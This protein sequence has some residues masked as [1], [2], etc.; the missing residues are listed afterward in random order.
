MKTKQL[1]D[2]NQDKIDNSKKVNIFIPIR[3]RDTKRLKRCVHNIKKYNLGLIDKI[4]VVDVGSKIPIKPIKKVVVE[5]LETST[6]NKA[7]ALNK[8]ILKYPNT[9]IMTCDVDTLLFKEHFEQISKSLNN[10]TFICDTNVR[11]INPKNFRDDYFVLLRKSK[12]WRNMDTQQ[13][14]NTANGGFQIYPYNFFQQMNGIQEGLGLYHGAVDNIV[15]YRA[16]MF[17][18]NIVDI[19]YPLLHMDHKKQKEENYDKEEREIALGYRSFKVGYID[20]VIKNNIFRNPETI[21]GDTCNISLFSEYK[22]AMTNQNKLIEEAIN[23]KQDSVMIGYQNFKL[24]KAQ[25][26]ILVAVINNTG[27]VPDFFMYDLINLVDYTRKLGYTCDIQ[28]VNACDVNSLRNAAVKV[29][30]GMNSDN[31]VYDYLVQ[32]DDDHRYPPEFI[33]KFIKEMEEKKIPIMTGLTPRKTFPYQNT[34]YYKNQEE[35]MAP[36]NI[37]VCKKPTDKIVDIEISGPVGMVINTSVF[38]KIPYPW[39]VMEFSKKK[40]KTKK[41]INNNGKLEEIEIETLKDHQTGGDIVF[42]RKLKEYGYGI[43]LD[44]SVSFA[45]KLDEV[46]ANRNKLLERKPIL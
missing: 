3:D 31:K 44:L 45:H 37:V 7:W 21:A 13:F 20:H 9:Y 18:L 24:E 26:S 30:L 4:V 29:A 14:L 38:Q 8:M 33:S 15:Y 12:P 43:K 11:R 36:E 17:G 1:L 19:S 34:Q 35:L 32:L 23:N 41:T 42:A 40:I 46:F 6:W 10:N 25:P 2:A 27:L 28:R 5:R 22:S 16:R 39:Y